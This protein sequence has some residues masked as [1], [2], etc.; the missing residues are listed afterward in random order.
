MAVAVSTPREFL[1]RYR[2]AE[3][4]GRGSFGRVLKVIDAQTSEPRALKVSAGRE[5]MLLDEFEQLARLR[6]PSLPKV[7]EV[8][9]TTEPVDDVAAGAPFFV[10]EWIAGGRCDARRWDEPAGLWSLMADIAGALAVIHA[11]GLVHGDVAPPN[12]LLVDEGA[13]ASTSRDGGPARAV[14]V[15]LGLA[16]GDGARGT[17]QYMAPEALA[18]HVEPRSDLYGLGATIVRLVTGKPPFD[19]PTLGELVQRIVGASAPPALPGVPRPLADL[20]G[21]LIARDAD[22]RPPSAVA[23]LDELDQLAPVVAPGIVR[24]ARPKVGAPPA[25]TA[26]PGA[27]SVIDALAHGLT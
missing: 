19:A 6:H 16:S 17:P 25:P 22:Q 13:A 7:F 15:D 1:G 3:L 10:A 5:G 12:I 18:G 11:A 21:R 14:L 20:V 9:R 26:W 2:V 4:I 23:V 24:R 8:G 27:A